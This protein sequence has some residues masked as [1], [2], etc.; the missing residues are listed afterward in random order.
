MCLDHIWN[1]DREAKFRN[2]SRVGED[3]KTGRKS[4]RQA[5]PDYRKSMTGHSE[6]PAIGPVLKVALTTQMTD[7]SLLMREQAIW[8]RSLK[9]VQHTALGL[10]L[11]HRDWQLSALS[12]WQDIQQLKP[13]KNVTEDVADR[14]RARA[15]RK[16]EKAE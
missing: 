10:K 13:D 7:I 14:T 1:V 4:G 5:E 6:V 11:G 12:V 16:I 9:W 15:R 2:Q 3:E 8:A